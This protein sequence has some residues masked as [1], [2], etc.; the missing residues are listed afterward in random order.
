M[1]RIFLSVLLIG[2]AYISMAQ[3][4]RLP[5]P[6]YKLVQKDSIHLRGFV[7]KYDSRPAAGIYLVSRQLDF[8]FNRYNL[9]A[10]TDSTGYFEIKGALPNDTLIIR[11]I[12]GT[13]TYVN[14]GSRYMVVYLPAEKVNNLNAD[15][16]IEVKAHRVH[17]LIKPTFKIIADNEIREGYFESGPEFPGGNDKFL[18]F[19]KRRLSYPEKAVASNI[20]G[21]VEAAF[22]IGP[23]GTLSAVKILKGIGYGCDEELIEILNKSPHWKPGHFNGRSLIQT[24]TVTVEFKL[25]D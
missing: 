20:E 14:K 25:T 16:P 24:E 4:K 17:S 6:A 1:R 23:D 5:Q 12:D 11:T 15:A 22:T 18:A 8:Q 13:L 10:K 2:I 19:V 21:T 3:H 9:S 7:Y